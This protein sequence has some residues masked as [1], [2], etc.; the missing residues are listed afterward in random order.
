MMFK[1]GLTGGIGTGK[2]FV[3]ELFAK[4]GIPVYDA[5]SHAKNLYLDEEV[6]HEIEKALG[7]NILEHGQVNLKKVSDLIFSDLHARELVEAI[8]HPRLMNDFAIWCSSQN[9]DIVMMEA[10][11]L[12]EAHFDHLFD[13]I[14]TVD[15]P[16]DLRISRLKLRNPSWSLQ[17][18]QQ[19]MFSQMSQADKCHR[20]DFV[21]YN[22]NT[23]PL[24][25]Q[26]EVFLAKIVK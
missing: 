5:D 9:N 12:F 25:K 23:Q 2:S 1:I 13:L 15:A 10:A 7:P 17:D 16:D 4:K 11:I 18:I 6:I 8:I 22:D 19:R 3:A 20:S 24:Q 21:I 14:V 26:I